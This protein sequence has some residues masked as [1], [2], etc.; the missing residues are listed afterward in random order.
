[1]VVITLICVVLGVAASYGDVVAYLLLA[2]LF[3][4]TAVVCLVVASFSHRRIFVLGFSIA[5]ALTF[6]ILM[7]VDPSRVDHRNPDN[8]WDYI[9]PF[10]FPMATIPPL[11]ALIFGGAALADD[12]WNRRRAES[13][14]ENNS[15][16]QQ[17]KPDPF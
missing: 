10:A 7:H 14:I 13:L 1:M 17:S 4:P 12:L 16:N 15:K 9:G 8:P 3:V 5:G 11:G 6:S 2:S